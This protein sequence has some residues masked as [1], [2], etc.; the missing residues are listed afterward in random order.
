MTLACL[1]GWI[2]VAGTPL[3]AW[4]LGDAVG[5][6]TGDEKT[7][8]GSVVLCCEMHALMRGWGKGCGYRGLDGQLFL[9][10]LVPKVSQAWSAQGC[11]KWRKRQIDGPA[12]TQ[13]LRWGRDGLTQVGSGRNSSLKWDAAT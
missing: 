12:M 5:D 4:R 11:G 2:E 9:S 10:S 13:G 7:K 3:L 1:H 6:G 8:A